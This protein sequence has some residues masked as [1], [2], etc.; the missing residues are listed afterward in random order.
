MQG[1]LPA[2][3]DDLRV[4]LDL[5]QV[6]SLQAERDAIWARVAAVDFL[7]RDEKRAAVGYGPEAATGATAGDAAS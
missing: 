4:E 5:D 7:S 1:L 2:F 3:G 6:P